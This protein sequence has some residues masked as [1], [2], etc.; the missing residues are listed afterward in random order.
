M[1]WLYLLS[2]GPASA[3]KSFGALDQIPGGCQIIDAYATPGVTLLL[4]PGLGGLYDAYL[5][6]WDD[7]DKPG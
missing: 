5:R 7:P 1:V 3:L 6:S 4:V 2:L